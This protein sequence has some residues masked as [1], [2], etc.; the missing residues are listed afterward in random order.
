VTE[1]VPSDHDAVE[2]HRVH[3]DSVGRTSR[4]QLP[5]PDDLDSAVDDVVCLCFDGSVFYAQ[6]E[7]TLDGQPAI[8]RAATD[9]QLARS[10][11]GEDT[12]G[13][14]LSDAG[15]S[16]GDPLLLDVLTPGWAY[17][18]R[19]PGE[20]VVYSPP[21]RPDDSLASIARDLDGE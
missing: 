2:S 1:R 3:L 15:L 16:G 11:D 5:L 13:A 14:W 19:L 21:A 20:R 4:V 9:Q 18:L 6:V 8:R 17:G 12:L 10:G 7:T